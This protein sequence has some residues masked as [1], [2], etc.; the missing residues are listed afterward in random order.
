MFSRAATKQF[1]IVPAVI[2]SPPPSLFSH[3]G[4]GQVS[5]VQLPVPGQ[6]ERLLLVLA[7]MLLAFVEQILTGYPAG[8]GLS[9]GVQV[10][11]PWQG[12]TS[13]QFSISNSVA[14]QLFEL[15][16]LFSCRAA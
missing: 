8:A 15:A 4:T 6:K 2:L 3:P 5:A 9:Q 10:P 1:Y 7:I 11:V 16:Q 12:K 13:N 14:L